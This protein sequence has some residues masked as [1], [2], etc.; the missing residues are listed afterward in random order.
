[1]LLFTRWEMKPLSSPVWWE[2]PVYYQAILM[3]FLQCTFKPFKPHIFRVNSRINNPI[4]S[5]LSQEKFLGVSSKGRRRFLMPF[6]YQKKLNPLEQS[7]CKGQPCH[8]SGRQWHPVT[9]HILEDC[10][11]CKAWLCSPFESRTTQSPQAS[12][13]T[14]EGQGKKLLST[15]RLF[16]GWENIHHE[17]A[18]PRGDSLV[19][20]SCPAPGGLLW[21]LLP[22]ALTCC[23]G[24]PCTRTVP[25]IL[26]A[27]KIIG[28]NLIHH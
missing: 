15:L 1:M 16:Q 9:C 22:I 25:P 12:F 19:L 6:V 18:N 27:R 17:P 20:P 21:E 14:G 26:S 28:E 4:I 5:S 13:E 23:D 10:T 3:T 7:G 2:M 11:D 24:Q 8:P